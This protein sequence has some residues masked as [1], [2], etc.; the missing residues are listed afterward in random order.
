MDGNQN[1]DQSGK[2]DT[3][4]ILV[5]KYYNNGVELNS[6]MTEQTFKIK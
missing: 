1:F 3:A 4:I 5:N 2:I 6:D